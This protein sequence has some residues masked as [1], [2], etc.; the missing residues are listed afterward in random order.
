MRRVEVPRVLLGVGADTEIEEVVLDVAQPRRVV[1]G[2]PG[3]GQRDAD[4][5]VGGVQVCFRHPNVGPLAHEIGRHEIGRAH[6]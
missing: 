5:G 2:Q 4:L 3:H 1:P 6:V